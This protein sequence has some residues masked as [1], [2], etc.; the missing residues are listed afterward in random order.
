MILHYSLFYVKYLLYDN[1]RR[2][3]YV[4][5]FIHT[6]HTFM[7]YIEQQ[8]THLCSFMFK[9]QYVQE[10][11]THLFMVKLLYVQEVVNIVT[12]NIKWVTT[13]WTY[14]TEQWV[15]TSWTYST[16]LNNGSRLFDFS[17]SFFLCFE[18]GPAKRNNIIMILN[19]DII[20][21][22]YILLL[23]YQNFITRVGKKNPIPKKTFKK[24]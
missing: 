4:H 22:L 3:K 18:P 9:L 17:E 13:S 16:L 11:V 7:S 14:S 24:L 8:C 12:Y 5:T 2:K 19:N 1:K 23:R 15:T 20:I 10:V 21:N 6:C